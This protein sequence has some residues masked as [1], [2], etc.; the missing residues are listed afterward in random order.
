MKYP[1]E[2]EKEDYG[3]IYKL[4]NEVQHFSEDY[5]RNGDHS[6]YLLDNILTAAQ[7]K[8]KILLYMAN[9]KVMT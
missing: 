3:E 2:L 4:L 5:I 9:H 8:R 1:I 6:D 7:L